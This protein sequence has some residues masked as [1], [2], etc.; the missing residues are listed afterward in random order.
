MTGLHGLMAEFLR[1]DDLLRAARRAHEEG[2]RRMDAYSPL[3]VHGLAET[4]GFHRTRLPLL[5][6][7]GGAIGAVGGFFLQYWLNAV[8]YPLNVGGRPLNSWPSFIVVSF[9][10]TILVAALTAVL[11]MFALNGLPR[12]NHPVFN[13]E[14]FARASRDRFFLCIETGD[15]LFDPERTRAFLASLEPAAL[16]EVPR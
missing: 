9:E 7:A 3:P 6:F 14:A 10:M 4:L 8:D 2:Y 5:V 1:P 16:H 13:A 12:P 11:G 15:P